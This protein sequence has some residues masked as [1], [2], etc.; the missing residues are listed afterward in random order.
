MRFARAYVACFRIH[1]WSLEKDS[2][3]TDCGGNPVAYDYEA[4]RCVTDKV[5]EQR[6]TD[7]DG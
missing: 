5:R 4:V 6:Y 3:T 7:V 1:T 2:S